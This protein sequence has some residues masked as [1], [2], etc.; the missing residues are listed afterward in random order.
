MDPRSARRL[1]RRLRST[2]GRRVG[3]D[4]ELSAIGQVEACQRRERR[5][6]IPLSDHLRA[7]ILAMLGAN[8][9]WRTL[10]RSMGQLELVFGCFKPDYLVR[11]A[12]R[13]LAAEVD[14]LGCGNGRTRLQMEAIEPN[15]ET[16][17]LIES[18]FGCLD[19]F[20]E[21]GKPEAIAQLLSR[22][23]SRY[24]LLEVGPAIARE[25][26]KLVGV[27]AGRI[28]G[29]VRRIAGPERLGLLEG[30]EADTTAAVKVWSFAEQAGV[31]PVAL[32]N[33]LRM[34]GSTEYGEI[35]GAVPRCESCDLAP[36]CRFPRR[37]G[38]AQQSTRGKSPARCP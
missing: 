19:Q 27:R 3:V 12:P 5:E 24:K 18:E 26:L 11:M 4:T 2:L 31:H 28:S 21:R 16:M 22:P 32:D 15:I 9:P 25:Y 7:M 14:L 35:C 30:R 20:V 17:R 37:R 8:R 38:K 10:A 29:H 6:L 34:L 1:I 33:L 23:R 36:D 13:Q